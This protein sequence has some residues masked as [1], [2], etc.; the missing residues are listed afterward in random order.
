VE[1]VYVVGHRNPDTDS[2]V[3]AMAYAA[4][5]NA[6]GERQYVAARLGG[7]SDETQVVLDKF[8][9][10]PPM[11]L[12]NLRTQVRDVDFDTPPAISHAV[13][14]DHAWRIF[15]GSDYI[16]LPVTDEEGRFYGMLTTGDIASYDMRSIEEQVVEGIPVFNMLSALEG[17]I[18]NESSESPDRISGEVAIALP[19][20]RDGLRRIPRGGI[21]IIGDQPEVLRR[22]IDEQA[23]CVIVCQAEL[24]ESVR[25]IE[26]NTLI[27]TTPFD[28]YKTARLIYQS[29]QVSRICHTG[30]IVSFRLDDYIDDV[31]ETVL[32][33][34]YRCYPVLDDQDRSVG[35]LSR[36]H[37][38]RPNRK[39]VVLV[40]HN[41]ISQSVEGLDQA[42]IVAI[43]D[44]HRLADV[45]TGMPVYVRNEPV[46]AT[47]TIIAS[48]YQ[49]RGLMP[50]DQLAGLI[51]AAIV[52]DTVMF[53]SPTC[54]QRDIDMAKRMARIAGVSP[55]DLGREIFTA[56]DQVGKTPEELLFSDF[57]AFRIGGQDLGIGQIT[58][59]DSEKKLEHKD[60]FLAAMEV[61]KAERGFDMILLMI[62][63]V[64]REGTELI[65]L[66]G[67]E[68]IRQ[69]FGVEIKDNHAFL[70]GVMSRKKQIVPALS[71]LW[72]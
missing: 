41:E 38:I 21:L 34:R 28:P 19:Q 64:L 26:T 63:D 3:S 69:A 4:L 36:Y 62:T 30:Q 47:A 37:I 1:P 13:T 68:S 52:S 20:T 44:H 27:I 53:K 71:A 50:S 40:D 33:S 10:E 12:R 16:A 51:C 65:Y 5:Q 48:M 45:Q 57:K 46:G 29:V 11:L 17:R 23:G 18:F 60:A 54:T 43:I 49:E 9:F 6:L 15:R 56:S 59:L 55:M 70:K 8:G 67:E 25:D 7:V 2:I 35:T 61:A 66:G 14:V 24:D 22:S 72:G 31:R 42:E 39:K 32:Q 58:C